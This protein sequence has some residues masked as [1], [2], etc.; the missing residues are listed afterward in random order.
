MALAG[1]RPKALLALSNKRVTQATAEELGAGSTK[2]HL[3][4]NISGAA[5]VLPALDGRDTRDILDQTGALLWL[6]VS[7]ALL[8][9]PAGKGVVYHL[10]GDGLP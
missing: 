8:V 3:L 4:P 7:A 9:N 1:L 5:Y 10:M 2:G 6:A